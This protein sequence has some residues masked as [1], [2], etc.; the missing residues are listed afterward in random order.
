VIAPELN[1]AD[2][3]EIPEHLRRQLRF[4]FVSD[5]SQVLAAALAS[6]RARA[7]TLA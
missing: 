5:V 7:Y 3:E 2:I 6:R 4:V 1:E